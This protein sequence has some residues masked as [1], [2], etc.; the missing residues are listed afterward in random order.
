MTPNPVILEP[1][2]SV[3][4][5]VPDSYTGDIM[6]DLNTRRARIKGIEAEGAMQ[7]ILADVPEAELY[8]YSTA[9]RSMTQGRGIHNSTFS[10][11]EAMPRN[12]QKQV[13]A[14]MAKRKGK[15]VSLLDATLGRR[16]RLTPKVGGPPDV[17]AESA[18]P[19]PTVRPRSLDG[20]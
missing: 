10:R 8:Q 14:D 19:R 6:G 7:K 16:I 18:E 12:V 15:P 5:T 4:V 3:S 2:H 9:V 17:I 13:V 1:I 20:Q 11:Y